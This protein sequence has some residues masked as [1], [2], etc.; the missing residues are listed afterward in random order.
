M[1][2][3]F[4]SSLQL[5]VG[6]TAII[7]L[8][9]GTL[10]SQYG[11]LPGSQAAI[12]V[13]T[14]ASLCV[15]ITLVVMAV[16]NLGRLIYYVASPVMQ[17]FTIGA[18]MIIGL[19]QLKNAF[20]FTASTVPQSGQPGYEYNY[21]VMNWYINHWNDNTYTPTKPLSNGQRFINPIAQQVC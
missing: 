16:L 11:A 5:A 10:I 20:G 19:Q 6:P 3:F 21:Q 15:G 7:S 4:G 13:A 14:Q 12:D 18:A 1:Y 9:T 8:L 2:T 17:G